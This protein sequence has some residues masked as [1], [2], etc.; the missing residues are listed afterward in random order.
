MFFSMEPTFMPPLEDVESQHLVVQV[1]FH[2]GHHL[3]FPN[4]Y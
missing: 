2:V 4:D 1:S 3:G